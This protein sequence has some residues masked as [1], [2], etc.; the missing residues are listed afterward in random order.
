M[1]KV[2]IIS[3]LIFSVFNGIG[4][5]G[6]KVLDAI[7]PNAATDK[8]PT[9]YDIYGNGGYMSFATTKDRD[10]LPDQRKKPGMLI[11]VV[12]KDQF[13]QWDGTG[14]TWKL[15]T[16]GGTGSGMV[17]Q[18]NL[19]AQP[20]SPQAG[21]AYYNTTNNTSYIFNATS[22]KWDVLGQN[23]PA[24]LWQGQATTDPVGAKQNWAYYNTIDKASYIYDGAK[25]QP[26]SSGGGGAS[27]IAWQGTLSAA[28]S[29][30]QAGWAY[31][32]T[33][34]NTTY[35][36]NANT[37]NWD[38]LGQ[39]GPFIQW[40]GQA[41]SPPAGAQLNWA[42]YNTM[43]KASYIYDGT[44]WKP[45]VSGGGTS[46]PVT[47]F[48]GS[49]PITNPAGNFNG[50]NPNT[51][52]IVK[53][54][55]AVFYPSQGPTA[56]LTLTYNGSTSSSFVLE[57]MAAGSSSVDL[58]WTAGKQASTDV[59][60]TI[61]VNGSNPTFTDPAQGASVSGTISG[62]TI[63]NNTDKSFRIDVTTKDL[64]TASATASISFQWKRYW[65]FVNTGS[66]D[67]VAY[68]PTNADIKGLPNSEFGTSRNCTKSVAAPVSPQKF[69]IAFPSAWD[70]STQLM[71]NG[72]DNTGA[73]D[74]QI[75][76][77]FTNASGGT[78]S[79]VVYI[80]KYNTAG[81]VNFV[82]Q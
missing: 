28:P 5:S 15:I 32:N 21:W 73:F 16:F 80:S 53:W 29:S 47:A 71:V 13:F 20:V 77:S 22:G 45:F 8:Y 6:V 41:A 81:S 33:S 48:N 49:R 10:N 50:I 55:E 68:V 14:L 56:G 43:D 35:I 74:K 54:I 69:F 1:K 59:I 24:I 78:T 52:D 62:V 7:V 72:L 23:G 82:V 75:I 57:Q 66:A 9:H 27:G 2:Y 79:Y 36:Y 60:T 76:T 17:W 11:Y 67:G 3:L 37:S 63:T 40:Q 19:G 18:G 58:N 44:T 65:G 30:P 38:I 4:Q 31:Y 39:V 51:N 34:N 46:G 25:W 61:T 64:K 70:N 12:D 26:F 42:Y